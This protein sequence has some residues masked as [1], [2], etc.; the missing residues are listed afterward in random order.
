MIQDTLKRVVAGQDLS[1][2]DAAAAMNEIMS[3]NCTDAQVAAFIIGLRMKGETVDEIAG[4]AEVMRD[5]AT[6]V[7]P[8]A[9][10][11]QVVDTCGTG[12]DVKGTFNISTA[13]AFVVAGA[14]VTV[15]KHGNKSVSSKSGSAD[16][17]G[18][19]GV[20]VGADTATVE[21][22]LREARIGFL[23]ASAL[24]AAMKY[25]IGPR[26]EVGVRTVFNI[27]GPLTNPSRAK[28]QVLGVYDAKL[29]PLMANVLK[30]MG[31]LRCF[32]VHG[33]DGMDEITLADRTR[34]AELAR[35]AVKE[36]DIAPE[37]FGLARASL[38]D[39]TVDTAEQS[40]RMIRSVL[41]GRAGPARD[42]V[43]LNAAAGIVAVGAAADLAEGIKKAAESIDSGAAKA[44]LD[45]MV[46]ITNAGA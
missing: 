34:V 29:A 2:A 44:A 28:C 20:N 5:K 17:L 15:A 13:A 36:Y 38:D 1:K 8:S 16:V 10:P 12:G 46:E 45:K 11:E 33:H 42:I 9:P 30:S 22:S 26:R 40:A 32:V 6:Y 25:A 3:G 24:H 31:S 41:A 27:L 37:D 39:L 43:L 23:F 21:K 35:G 7:D 4:C 18:A 19:L 14:G